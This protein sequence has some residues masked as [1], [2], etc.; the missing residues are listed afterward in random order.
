MAKV[1]GIHFQS[2]PV[3]DVDRALCFYRDRLGMTVERNAPYGQSRWVFM[4]I[5]G[6]DTLLHFD[7][8]AEVPKTKTPTLV[9]MCDD[10]DGV[11]EELAAH[12]V[13]IAHAP[14]D[15]PWEPGTRWAIIHD[16][17]GN[18]VLLQTVKGDQN[19]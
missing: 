2:I 9:L 1:L 17:E 4:Q 12:E 18:Q 7:H 10:V 6:A 16:S 14:Q 15:A 11:C 5:P 3:A 8:V 19:G 13:N